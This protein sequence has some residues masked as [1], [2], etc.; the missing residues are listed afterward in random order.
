MPASEVEDEDEDADDV[1]QPK[2]AKP[3]MAATKAPATMRVSALRERHPNK[4]KNNKLVNATRLPPPL[5][6]LP[7]FRF[8]PPAPVTEELEQADELV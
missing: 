6:V 8:P 2:A 5:L 1:P 7:S 4:P 3:R